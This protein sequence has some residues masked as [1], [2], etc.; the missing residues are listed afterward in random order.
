MLKKAI[1][2]YPHTD[3]ISIVQ[4]EITDDNLKR[5]V[6]LVM[7]KVVETVGQVAAQLDTKDG[8]RP[9]SLVSTA[10]QEKWGASVLY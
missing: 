7:G 2:Q 4:D 3:V 9:T 8:Y 5:S 6:K 10:E 1:V